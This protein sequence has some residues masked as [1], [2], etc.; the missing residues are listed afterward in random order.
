MAASQF[1]LVTMPGLLVCHIPS[2]TSE[3]AVQHDALE[4][5][6]SLAIRVTKASGKR[7]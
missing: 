7:S 2:T 5:Y 3:E 6:K 4:R 1:L